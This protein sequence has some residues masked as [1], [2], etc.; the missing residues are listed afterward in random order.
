MTRS[1]RPRRVIVA[2]LLTLAVVTGLIGMFAVWVNRQALNTD[3][4]TETSGQLLENKEIQTALSAYLVD[5]LFSNVDVAGEIR[6]QL[7]P[8]A[9]ALAAPVAGGLQE[10]AGRVAP[11]LLAS[12]KVQDA[13]RQ[14]NR[15]AHEELLAVL[16]GGGDS[17]STANGVVTLHLNSIVGR[18]AARLGISG[19]TLPAAVGELTILRADELE[20]A[21]SVAKG[22]R[23]LAIVF[24]AVPLLLF[25]LAIWLA[26]GWRRVALRTTGWCFIGLG[27][28]VLLARRVGGD[29]L[30]DSLAA[31]DSVK[32]AVHSVWTISTTLLYDI[33][34]GFVFYGAAFVAAA[35]LAGSTRPATALRGALAPVLRYHLA[36]AYGALTLLYLLV[37]AW[38][39]TP[40]MRK[41]LG[42][43][44]FAALLVLGLELLRRQ[45]A[46]EFPDAEPGDTGRAIRGWLP[47][48]R[49]TASGA[50]GDP[51]DSVG[52]SSEVSGRFGQLEQLAALHDR[53][54][55]S[56]E[57]FDSQKVL[58]LNGGA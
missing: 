22:V 15:A 13:W 23:H 2:V 40:A 33:A 28:V 47:G 48:G 55:L 14:A 43:I 4:W 52:E 20:T 6:S 10:L 45:T 51:R 7:P 26:T 50:A 5:Q 30:V 54:V 9:T 19:V 57:E 3:N 49:K 8:Q 56:D 37:L 17:V 44:A 38:G 58:I 1:Q 42:I 11:R 24:T 46:R 21:Q 36:A 29:Q 41:P 27:I 32:P 25:A 12:P 39:P 16:D 18:L 34:A 35:W 31:S 53:G